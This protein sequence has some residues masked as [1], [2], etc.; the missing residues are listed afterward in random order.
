MAIGPNLAFSLAV[1]GTLA[2]YFEFVR[3]GRVIPGL[4][5]ALLLISGGYWLAR[6][7]PAE[8][9][10]ILL[11]GAALLFVIEAIWNTYF[12]AAL[13]GTI[14]MG[15]GA[16]QLFRQEPR[17]HPALAV[18]LSVVFGGVT[19]VLACSARKSRKN[20]WSDLAS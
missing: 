18:G 9:G 2:V 5:G 6:N 1:L 19:A 12:V 11:T 16:L 3:P 10:I 8:R 15:L 13:A 4:I 7:S 14:A 20:K 17:I